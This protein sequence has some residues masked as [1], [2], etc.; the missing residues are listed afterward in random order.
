MITEGS[1]IIL[2]TT[3]AIFSPCFVLKNSPQS[4]TVRYHRGTRRDKKTGEYKEDYQVETISM[5]DVETMSE[6]I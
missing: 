4:I 2:R 3:N 5:K 6:R 1:R